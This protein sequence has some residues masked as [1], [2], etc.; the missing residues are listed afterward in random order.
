MTFEGGDGEGMCVPT[1]TLS[2]RG[3]NSS[4]LA[5]FNGPVGRSSI[6]LAINMELHNP[7]VTIVDATNTVINQ[8]VTGVPVPFVFGQPID[9]TV[10]TAATTWIGRLPSR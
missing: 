8:T 10:R 3:T 6:A 9:R 2:G 7:A 4:Q 1:F 5:G